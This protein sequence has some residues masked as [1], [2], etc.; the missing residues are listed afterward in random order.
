MT[1]EIK[2]KKLFFIKIISLLSL[3]LVFIPSDKFSSPYIIYVLALLI[4]NLSNLVFSSDLFFSLICIIG[5]IMM[6]NKRKYV[7][8][9]GYLLAPLLI[10]ILLNTRINRVNIWVWLPIMIFIISAGYVIYLEFKKN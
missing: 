4:G 1:L 10:P 8:L 7:V 9:I 2:N 3:C 5:F 6:F